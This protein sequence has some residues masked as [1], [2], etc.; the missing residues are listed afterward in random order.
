MTAPAPGA[1][2]VMGTEELEE[3]LGHPLVHIQIGAQR[4]IEALNGAGGPVASVQQSLD[5]VQEYVRPGTEQRLKSGLGAG[6]QA[7]VLVTLPIRRAFIAL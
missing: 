2:I 7:L 4:R 5:R 1:Q 3:I 6:E